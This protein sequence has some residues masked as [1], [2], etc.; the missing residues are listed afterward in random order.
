M[1]E[2]GAPT[3]QALPLVINAIMILS[4]SAGYN[5]K[6]MPKDKSALL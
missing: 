6:S 3:P 4:S 2:R 1:T 5:C